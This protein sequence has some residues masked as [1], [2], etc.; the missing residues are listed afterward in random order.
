MET[1]AEMLAR[2]AEE[3]RQM[4]EEIA[5]RRAARAGIRYTEARWSEPEP[6]EEADDAHER[7][8]TEAEVARMIDAKVQAALRSFDD[9][10][11]SK[12]AAEV[13]AVVASIDEAR[14]SLI[15]DV[16]DEFANT[17]SWLEKLAERS[18]ALQ[19]RLQIVEAVQRGEIAALPRR[20]SNDDAKRA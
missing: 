6:D 18:E 12:L 17:V 20:E 19:T 16:E 14:E 13:D 3:N 11:I 1:K 10:I 2:L 15:G 7:Q 8:L 5:E 9:T 4:R